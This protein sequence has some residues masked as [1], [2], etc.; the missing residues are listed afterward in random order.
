M[1]RLA[2]GLLLWSAVA[3]VAAGFVFGLMGAGR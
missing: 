3:M 1:I 2:V